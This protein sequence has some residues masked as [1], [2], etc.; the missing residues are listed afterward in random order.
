V[1]A[2]ERDTLKAANGKDSLDAQGKPIPE[3]HA[4]HILI[5]VTPNDSDIARSR[6]LAERVRDEAVKGTSFTTLVHRYSHY[7]GPATPDGDVGFVSLGNLQDQIREGLDSL[8]VGQVSEV[9]TNQSGFNI[10]KVTD[11]HPERD[12]TVD[13][14]RQDLPDA[15]AQVQFREKYEA[16]LKTLRA[17][18]QIQYRS[19]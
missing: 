3:A 14:I 11:R 16:W 5:R 13:E 15:V 9:L 17:K 2:L 6:A 19:F 18:A 12:Y 10:F 1:Q 7:D 4:R 8:E